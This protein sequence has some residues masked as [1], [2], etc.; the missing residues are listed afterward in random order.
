MLD[1]SFET[2]RNKLWPGQKEEWRLKI[3]G[4]NKDKV[5]AE[6][7]ATLYDASL[8]AFRANGWS[9][10]IYPSYWAGRGWR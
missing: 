10:S 8:D 5:A 3:A 1:I 6:M 7:V 2:F 9:F 4:A